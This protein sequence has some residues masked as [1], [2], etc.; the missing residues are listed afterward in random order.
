MRNIILFQT[1]LRRG[2]D[3]RRHNERNPASPCGWNEARRN[4]R[5]TLNLEI[6]RKIVIV[7]NSNR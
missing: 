6:F 1:S 5:Q 7:R 2:I 4:L 3:Q